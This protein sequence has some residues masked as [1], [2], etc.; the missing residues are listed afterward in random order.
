MTYIN[1][2]VVYAP[3][4]HVDRAIQEFETPFFLYCEKRIRENCRRFK[5]AFDKYFD[6]FEPL[7]AVKANPN[8]VVLD[9]IHQEGFDFDV[10]SEAEIWLCKKHG[11][12]GMHTA[13][14]VPASE[15]ARA[16]EANFMINLDDITMI[17]FMKEIG[18]PEFLSFR[19]NPGVGNG[20]DESCVTA[21][22]KAKYGIP[23][24]KAAEAYQ[25]AKEAGV[26]RFG[27]HMMTGSNV[28]IEEKDYFAN[29]VGR[30]LDIVSDVKAK[31]GIE[32]ELMNIGGG[33]GVP[34]HPDRPGLDM[35]AI[36]KSIRDTFDKKIA[37]HGIKEP[38]LMAEPGR[39]ITA[40]AGWLIGKVQVIKDSYKK[41]VGIDASASDMPR[42]S[43]Y[44]AYH[45]VSVHNGG[46]DKE[47]VSVVG[48]ICEN[49]DQFAKDREIS[50]CKVG[51]HIV[52]HNCGAHAYAMGHNYNGKL[53]HAEYL[54]TE[55]G[56][57]KK[58]RRAETIEDLYNTLNI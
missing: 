39:Y 51:D 3:S 50:R 24:E 38:Q 53:R 42:P 30:L 12:T 28:P 19:I 57:L 49:N 16:K 40:D 44:D 41:F 15:F 54:I 37:E 23:F 31:T 6:N 11:W 29:I 5:D 56:D 52:I 55:F 32:I 9:I 47:V 7:Y 20:H 48:T 14:Y 58:I 22:P 27:I 46:D 35:D 43:I 8:P 2:N 18:V 33:F 34:Y 4:E 25:L 17:E 13:N 36:A 21:G 26:Q 10:S 1:E 45:F